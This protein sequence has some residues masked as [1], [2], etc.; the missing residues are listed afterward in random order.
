MLGGNP[1]VSDASSQWTGN[2]ADGLTFSFDVDP[3]SF[4]QADL[5]FQ[6]SSDLGGNWNEIPIG[7]SSGTHAGGVVVSV[8]GVSVTI[9]VPGHNT[10]NGRLFGRLKA[11]LP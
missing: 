1:L 2:A 8:S 7:G 10:T 6:W 11:E 5:V 4:G 9:H 3:D